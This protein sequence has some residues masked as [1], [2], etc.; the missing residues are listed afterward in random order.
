MYGPRL[1]RH[2][3]PMFFGGL[4]LMV[5]AG[6]IVVAACRLAWELGPATMEGHAGWGGW[7]R[8]GR[9]LVCFGS[10][11]STNEDSRSSLHLGART[12]IYRVDRHH[13]GGLPS[14]CAKWRQICWLHKSFAAN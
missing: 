10:S 5:V 7:P 4:V 12:R 6:W 1:E 9:R 13:S 2:G 8:S 14:R 11:L 3:D